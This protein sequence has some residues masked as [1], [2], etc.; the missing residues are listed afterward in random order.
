MTIAKLENNCNLYV[1]G[2]NATF[3]IDGEEVEKFRS[4][5]NLQGDS[6]FSFECKIKIQE[7]GQF[8][9]KFTAKAFQKGV[10]IENT[11]CYMHN[12]ELFYNGYDGYYYSIQPID[13][14]QTILLCNG[15]VLHRNYERTL[16]VENFRLDFHVYFDRIA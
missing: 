3:Y 11:E 10:E 5:T 7:D 12:T 16:N 14:N 6:R 9:V 15:V 2:V 4:P 13:G 1:H 8:N